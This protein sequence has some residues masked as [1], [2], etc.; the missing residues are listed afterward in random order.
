MRSS[1]LR[2]GGDGSVSPD[3]PDDPSDDAAAT[4]V[5]LRLDNPPVNALTGGLL[6]GLERAVH[7][8][9][10]S[11][12]V[13]VIASAHPGVFMAGGDIE[14]L[15]QSDAAARER[16]VR[17]LQGVFDGFAR[18]DSAV[19]AKVE[20]H[21]LG[22]GLEIALAGD[23]IV[24][25]DAA[26]FGLPEVQLGILPA[27]G[28]IH[29]LV[30]RIGEGYARLLMLTG[31]R[32]D[33]RTAEARGV[34][35]VVCDRAEIDDLIDEI[36]REIAASPPEAVRAIKR[37]TNTALDRSVE[38]GLRE[39]L[40]HWLEARASDDAQRALDRLAEKLGKES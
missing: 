23:I 21:C 40:A 31:R 33:A 27:A 1:V 29:R 36:S 19:I 38:A 22:G 28:G 26:T 9:P 16:Y 30:R 4:I 2:I 12:R 5:T 39:E 25:S 13:V 7:L 37:L 6:D 15:R 18:L 34:V 10:P 3:L 14:T 24:A 20:G 35:D 17:R 11:V 8:L 32:I